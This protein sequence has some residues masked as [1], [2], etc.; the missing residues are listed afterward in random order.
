MPIDRDVLAAMG[1]T[2]L[3]TA[4]ADSR[5]YVGEVWYHPTWTFAVGYDASIDGDVL[6]QIDGHEQTLADLLDAMIYWV[7]RRD[8]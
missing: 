4:E 5:G 7:K 6:S 2:H 1:F 8:D 3:T